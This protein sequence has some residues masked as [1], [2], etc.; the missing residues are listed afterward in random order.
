MPVNAVGNPITPGAGPRQSQ[1]GA[2]EGALKTHGAEQPY[3]TQLS[4]A[5]QP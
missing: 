4:L 2:R 3:S 1:G 5:S